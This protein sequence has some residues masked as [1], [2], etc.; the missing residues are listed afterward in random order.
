MLPGIVPDT[1]KPEII[2]TQTIDWLVLDYILSTYIRINKRF[3]EMCSGS[4]ILE[5]PEL[6]EEVH[7]SRRPHWFLL[8]A[9][10]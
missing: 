3:E 8:P 4:L 2:V 6:E 1:Y 5:V 7:L 10:R 9:I